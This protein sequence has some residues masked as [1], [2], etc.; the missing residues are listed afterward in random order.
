M[1]KTN[2]IEL[3]VT[4][5]QKKQIESNAHAYGYVT[6]SAYLRDRGLELFFNAKGAD[7]KEQKT[8]QEFG[9]P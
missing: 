5:T 7:V 4:E 6:I 1:A 3:R 2:R 8:L 9:I